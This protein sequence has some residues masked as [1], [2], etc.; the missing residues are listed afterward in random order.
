MIPESAIERETLEKVF[1]DAQALLNESDS[2]SCVPSSSKNCRAV[3][4]E[5]ELSLSVIC[6]HTVALSHVVGKLLEYCMEVKKKLIASQAK[7]KTALPNLTA[8]MENNLPLSHR[9]MKANEIGKA[10]LRRKSQGRKQAQAKSPATSKVSSASSSGTTQPSSLGSAVISSSYLTPNGESFLSSHSRL[11]SANLSSIDTWVPP[12]SQQH[13]QQ[14]P[15]QNQPLDQ[16]QEAPQP[17]QR[18]QH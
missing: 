17:K 15:R 6:H 18:G 8:G 14:P 12:N 13:Q 2:I 7:R 3:R 16:R 5:T 4:N 10:T 11:L 1:R 9:G